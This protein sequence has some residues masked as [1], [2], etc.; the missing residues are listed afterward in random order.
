MEAVQRRES[1]YAILG[2]R[3]DSSLDEIRHAYRKLAMKWHPDRWSRNASLVGEAKRTFQKIQEAYSVLSDP[4][5]R[6]VY[7]AGLYD[8]SDEYDE[9][10]CDFMQEMLDLM[11]Q[12]KEEE[13]GC[14][15]E[16][17]QSMFSDLSQAFESPQWFCNPAQTSNHGCSTGP[18]WSASSTSSQRSQ[19]QVS[20]LGV[21]GMTSHCR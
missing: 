17:L 21:F 9:G 12:V 1:Y 4:A 3:S 10:F 6:A 8:P 19:M 11:A 7:N 13:K 20:E 18:Y 15:L 2:V 16:E 5:K 14:S